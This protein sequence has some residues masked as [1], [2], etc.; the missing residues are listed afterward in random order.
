MAEILI[1][2]VFYPICAS[3][4]LVWSTLLGDGRALRSRMS[5]GEIEYAAIPDHSFFELAAQHSN[6]VIFE[7]HADHGA[8]GCSD[9]ISYWLPISSVDLPDVLRWLPPASRVVFCCKDATEQLNTRT[10]TVLLQLGVG[11]VYF[12]D[13]R[14]VFQGNRWFDPEVTTH[15]GNRERRKITITETRRCS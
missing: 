14:T 15:D 12:L 8:G 6:L 7:M 2:F 5:R 13:D 1:I 4:V 11:T 9:L 10:K 3:V